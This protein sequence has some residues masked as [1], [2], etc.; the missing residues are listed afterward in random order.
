MEENEIMKLFFKTFF[1]S[2]L[3][4]MCLLA[5]PAFLSAQSTAAEIEMLLGTRAVTYAQAARFVLEAAD[6][7]ITN[8]PE[9]AFNYA[10]QQNWLPKNAASGDLAKLDKISLLLMRSFDI[11][12]G[13]FY[14]ITKGIP[15]GSRY[16]YRELVYSSIIQGR[17]D[18]DMLVSGE[19][20][21]FYVNRIYSLQDGTQE[22]IRR[23][24]RRLAAEEAARLR[25]EAL[26]AQIAVLLAEQEMKDTTVEATDS[27]VKITLSNINFAADSWELPETEK[28]KLQEIARVLANISN[29]KLLIAGHT[30]R[31]GAEDYLL[32]LSTN[33][34]QSVAD[35]LVGLGACQAINIRIV[36][37][38]AD[39]L[40]IE[41]TS[42]AALAANRRV[43]IT[44]ED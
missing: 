1:K 13:L 33:R 29:V 32:L 24:E 39:R 25:R 8:N 7:R 10:V 44:V 22:E 26:A 15:L 23:R 18:P 42:P 28:S 6:A 43:E 27:G 41:G 20:L 35:Y 12:G 11:R 2:C 4:V 31:I 5:V 19:R 9:E 14:S 40:L 36:G 17:H 3:L 34:A 16:A 30:T 37:Y 38:G 21:I